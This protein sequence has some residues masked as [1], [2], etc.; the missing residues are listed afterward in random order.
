MP[1]APHPSSVP[2]WGEGRRPAPPGRVRSRGRT[3]R[4]PP[5]PPAGR[6]CAAR[7]LRLQGAAR[8]ADRDPRGDDARGRVR[9]PDAPGRRA[10][11]ER[12]HR[13]GPQ[14]R[15]DQRRDAEAPRC[16]RAR[17]RTPARRLLPPRAHA[18][19]DRPLRAAADRAG[20]RLRAEEAAQGS[21]RH[22][23]RGA[24]RRRLRATGAGDRRQPD[25]RL[26][27]RPARHHR[28]QRQ[29]RR[30]GSRVDPDRRRR[31]RPAPGRGDLPPQRRGRRHRCR[32]RRARLAG[33][34]ARLARQHRRRPRRHP[35][36]RARRAA[37]CGLRHVRG[38]R[39]RHLHRDVRRARQRHR[40][41]RS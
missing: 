5:D 33:Q 28:R 25:P 27:D 20:G 15:P 37:R 40:P 34:L 17:L 23:P 24:A 26:E 16:L 30:R 7:G 36:G 14:G 32:W 39:R 2:S 38:R 4:G 18:D 9:H 21:G 10:P 22:G 8:A 31:G 41:I 11:G 3:I 19:P 13:A 29:L 12:P 6:R 1:R 35:R